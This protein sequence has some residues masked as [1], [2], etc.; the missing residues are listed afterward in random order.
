MVLYDTDAMAQR[1]LPTHALKIR[2]DL[3]TR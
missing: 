1:V 2:L 3:A